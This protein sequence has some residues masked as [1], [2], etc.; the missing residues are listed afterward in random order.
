M[1]DKYN[2]LIKNNIIL[3]NGKK[4]L[5]FG[6]YLANG[7]RGMVVLGTLENKEVVIKIF[8]DKKYD[9]TELFLFKNVFI[10][11][12]LKNIHLISFLDDGILEDGSEFLIFEKYEM[13]LDKYIKQRTNK[14]NITEILSMWLNLSKTLRYIHSKGY[15]HH[16]ISKSNILIKDK[17]DLNTVVLSDLGE[18]EKIN[19]LNPGG[20]NIMGEHIL[21]LEIISLSSDYLEYVGD[22]YKPQFTNVYLKIVFNLLKRGDLDLAYELVEEIL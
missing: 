4:I 3:T 13:D 7:S 19:T 10:K 9:N 21:L 18:A 15:I 6:N 17:R 5:T 11:S 22:E 12:E 2:E 20:Y 16:D 14:L 8:T 1:D